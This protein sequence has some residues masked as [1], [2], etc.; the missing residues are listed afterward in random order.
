MS[1]LQKLEAFV[2]PFEFK[3]LVLFEGVIAERH[4]YKINFQ[5][6]TKSAMMTVQNV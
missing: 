3:N 2:V 1:Y 6:A 4:E 5:T